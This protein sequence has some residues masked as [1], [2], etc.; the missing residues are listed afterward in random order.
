[1][2]TMAPYGLQFKL[3]AYRATRNMWRNKLILRG[4]LAQTIFLSLIVGLIYL[5]I[6]S[7]LRGVQDRQG[8][9]FFLVVQVRARV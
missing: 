2:L 8:S 5:N 7:D 3:L 9:L 1:M 6:T 4:K